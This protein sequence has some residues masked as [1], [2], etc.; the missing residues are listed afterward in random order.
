[1]KEIIQQK[2]ADSIRADV[3]MLTSRTSVHVPNIPGKAFAVIGMR[4]AGKTSF[5]W[6]KIS[7]FRSAGISPERLVYFNFEDERLGEMNVQDL[8]LVV[9]EYYRL[10]P[11]YRGRQQVVFFFDEIQVVSGW[12][13]FTRRLLDSENVQL[14]L[15]G[16]S[17]RLLSREVATS[18]RGR[19]MEAIVYPFSFREFLVHAETFDQPPKLGKMTARER[20]LLE[21]S[22]LNYL[23]CG[24]FPEAQGRTL[25]D[26]N[27][28][29]QGYVD[30]VILRD[31]AERHQLTNLSAIRWLV[32][33]LLAN[34]G[35]AFS[36]NR[37]H[38]ALHSQ[39]IRGSIEGLLEIYAHLEDA[40]LIQGVRIEAGSERQR[41]VNP[42]K[43]YP[44]DQGLIA[45]FDRT[46][47]EN[48][49]HALET[50]VLIQL[51]R[52]GAEVTWVRTP[53]NYE[54]DFLASFPEGGVELI[55]VAASLENPETANREWRALVEAGEMFPRAKLRLI[56]L[57]PE[58]A[59][60]LPKDLKKTVC[61]AVDWMLEC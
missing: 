51:L 2:I 36:A 43:T 54:I 9:E 31:V 5:L 13:K 1:M 3:P 48:I 40:F 23:R 59:R 6:Q 14:W 37:F 53:S 50:C 41:Q 60:H 58:S 33:Q 44:V 21:A 16:S 45:A 61:A 32:R 46:G 52:R 4:R 42:V 57:D 25:R 39:G 24:G 8:S 28:L 56:T 47:K 18:M 11:E 12:E 55:Q 22:F 15:S 29:L 27:A 35:G 19:S 20:S 7:E 49:G 38:K 10:Y 17:A 34:A 30:S 26:R